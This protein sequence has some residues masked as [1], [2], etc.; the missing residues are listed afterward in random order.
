MD[1][2][3]WRRTDRTARVRY[4]ARQPGTARKLHLFAVACCRRVWPLL[5]DERSRR[6]VEVVERLADGLA[7]Q[8]DA[9]SAASAA[10]EAR[11]DAQAACGNGF[12][13]ATSAAQAALYCLRPDGADTV[14]G[15]AALAYACTVPRS[16]P[17]TRGWD[18]AFR[19][20]MRA[21]RKAHKALLDDLFGDPFA[22]VPFAPA[23]LTR[24]VVALS[25]ALYEERR[26][27]DL[28]ILGDALEDAGCSDPTVLGH[29]RGGE[30]ARGCWVVD[31][32]IGNR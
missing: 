19:A 15:C 12:G 28:P 20:A 22:P 25:Q 30:H 17:G 27:G 14:A 18:T 32:L 8:D 29:C 5:T 3:T 23:W 6:A 1:A 4:L 13:V 11:R 16:A 24:D 7:S 9:L 26:F 10:E 21:Q 2:L 31:G